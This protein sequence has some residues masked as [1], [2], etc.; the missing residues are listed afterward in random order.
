[1]S[2]LPATAKTL[3]QS[4]VFLALERQANREIKHHISRGF[5][6][7]AIVIQALARGLIQRKRYQ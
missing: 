5:N 7:A 1:V 2:L 6:N 4:V 3:S